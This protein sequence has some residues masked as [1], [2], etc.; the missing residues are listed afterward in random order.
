MALLE[1]IGNSV[2]IIGGTIEVLNAIHRSIEAVKDVDHQ[3]DHLQAICKTIGRSLE[4]IQKVLQQNSEK[5]DRNGDRASDAK[6]IFPLIESMQ[7]DLEHVLQAINS[8]ND[9]NMPTKWYRK[10]AML[11]VV[12]APK[13]KLTLNQKALD[14]IERSMKALGLA[15]DLWN[16]EMNQDQPDQILGEVKAIM[17]RLKTEDLTISST[18][19]RSSNVSG[20]EHAE[21]SRRASQLQT[22]INTVKDWVFQQVKR[23]TLISF[24][25]VQAPNSRPPTPNR[26]GS[27]SEARPRLTESTVGMKELQ[28]RFNELRRLSNLANDQDLPDIAVTF[29][30]EAIEIQSRIRELDH[31]VDFVSDAELEVEHIRIQRKCFEQSQRDEGISRLNELAAKIKRLGPSKPATMLFQA[32]VDVGKLYYDER[33][34]KEAVEFLRQALFQGDFL[35]QHRDHPSEIRDLVQ[36]IYDAYKKDDSHEHHGATHGPFLETIESIIGYNPL[37]DSSED[38]AMFD[39]LQKWNFNVGSQRSSLA[40]LRDSQGNYPIHVAVM[41]GNKD[42]DMVRKFSANEQTLNAVNNAGLTPLFIAVE[43]GNKERVGILLDEGASLN[44]RKPA[45]DLSYTLFHCCRNPDIMELLI[46]RMKPTRRETISEGMPPVVK[47]VT[48]NTKSLD[49]LTPLHVACE[50]N[51]HKTAKVLLEYGASIDIQNADGQ[52]A[53]IIACFGHGG[54][55]RNGHVK[56]DAK[57]LIELL[58]DWGSNVNIADK[59]QRTAKQGLKNSGFSKEE[60]KS[61]LV[62]RGRAKSR[63]WSQDSGLEVSPSTPRDT[64]QSD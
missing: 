20:A 61:M 12:R 36:T 58:V 56:A 14:R 38:K 62:S 4:R 1:P 59:D 37:A 13:I 19:T 33:M 54:L 52:T 23:L 27:V 8:H 57:K 25:S 7:L 60:I 15:I 24:E 49:S 50:H 18:E 43:A 31:L 40:D 53:L 29:H 48:I 51:D 35:E 3:I 22:Q 64:D 10:V 32:R 5:S 21:E 17:S 46:Q 47:P 45:T 34:Y 2:A 26:T 30:I 28:L 16:F 42:T 9:Q 39:F 11:N 41:P 63:D 6:F 55:R 44:V